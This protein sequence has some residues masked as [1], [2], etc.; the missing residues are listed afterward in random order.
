MEAVARPLSFSA[1][2]RAYAVFTKMRL[3]SLVIVSALSGYLFAGGNDGTQIFYL[4]LG[5]LLVTAASNGANQI[6]E[7]DLDAIMKRTQRRPIPM[8]LMSVKE[9]YFIVIFCLISGAV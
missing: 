6:W 3:A 8:G 4:L 1:K 7:R 5:G 2:I 9:A